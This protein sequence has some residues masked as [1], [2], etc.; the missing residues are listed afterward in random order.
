MKATAILLAGLLC[1]AVLQV[2]AVHAEDSHAAAPSGPVFV[3]VA[4]L[5]VPVF[6]DGGV[7]LHLYYVLQ[8]EAGDADAGARIRELMPRLR[9]AYL[10]A[11]AGMADRMGDGPM[12]DDERVKR[13]LSVASERVLGPHV[14]HEILI[15]RSF[16]RRAS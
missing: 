13:T 6:S 11:L 10:R 3:P 2:P 15:Q 14:V 5:V 1:G 16:S 9:D 12:P 4:P 8:L 7:R